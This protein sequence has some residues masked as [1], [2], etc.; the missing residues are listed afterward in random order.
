MRERIA[1]RVIVALR[2]I[3]ENPFVEAVTPGWPCP[4][5]EL[6]SVTN[7]CD[8]D[9]TALGAHLQGDERIAKRRFSDFEV[10][11]LGTT[12]NRFAGITENIS[13]NGCFVSLQDGAELA[14]GRLIALTLPDDKVVSGSVVWSYRSAVGIRFLVP[15]ETKVVDDLVK[16]SLHARLERFQPSINPTDRL[17]SLPKWDK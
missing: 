4:A 15:L 7:H 9:Q 5:T 16:R 1:G 10:T 3:A 14:A 17:T 8:R 11:L 6:T 12:G 13:E 2:G